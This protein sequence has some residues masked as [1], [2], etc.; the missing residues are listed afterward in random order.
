V[1]A[2]NESKPNAALK[3]LEKLIGCWKVSGETHGEVAFNWMEG[4]YFMVQDINLAGAKGI[5][6]IGYDEISQTLK[7]HYFDD[8]GNMLECIYEVSETDHVVSI[9]MPGIKGKFEGKFSSDG[10]MI[11]GNWKWTKES[12]QIDYFAT[13]T[14]LNKP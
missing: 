8:K 3:S 5:E 14:K 13:L 1:K 4:G 6:F 11:T 12:K 10:K 2:G 9:D 7:S